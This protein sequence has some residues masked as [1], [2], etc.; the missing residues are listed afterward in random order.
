MFSLRRGRKY[1]EEIKCTDDFVTW[2][3]KS[4]IWYPK[5]MYAPLKS[6][7]R[8]VKRKIPRQTMHKETN[9]FIGFTQLDTLEP[10]TEFDKKKESRLTKK[11][12]Y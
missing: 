11:F 8:A 4:D 9:D 5:E 3:K 2:I 7:Q 10:T 12:T 1:A 6:T